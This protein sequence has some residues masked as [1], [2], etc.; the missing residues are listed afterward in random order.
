M[1]LRKRSHVVEARTMARCCYENLFWIAALATKGEEF[2]KRME[3]DAAASRMKRAGGLLECSKQQSGK[4]DFYASLTAFRNELKE[5][6][7]KPDAI[8]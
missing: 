6:H 4:L 1:A 3:L 8:T 5:K 7:G 2:V